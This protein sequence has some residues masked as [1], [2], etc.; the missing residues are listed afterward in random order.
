MSWLILFD[1]LFR[2]PF[3]TGL[4]LAVLLSLTG[5]FLRMR[6]DWLSGLGLSQIAA[7]GGMAALPLHIPVMAGAFGAAGV[8]MLILPILPR[9]TNNHYALM[10]LAGWSLALLIGANSDHGEIIGESL[11]RGQL[12]FTFTPHLWASAIALLI[13]LASVRWLS[14]R[15][16]KQRFFPDF[17]VANRLP[18]W[19]H[20]FIFGSM[21]VA[22]TVLGT[23]SMGALPAFALLF[24]PSWIGF[25]LVDGWTRALAVTIA[26]GV[27]VYMTAF[28][29]A[30][31][32]DQPFGPI[33]TVLLALLTV[34]RWLPAVRRTPD[35]GD[36]GTILTEK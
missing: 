12:Y 16:L 31:L 4:C 3:I 28:V 17:F 26:I 9:A 15:L 25:V 19:R 13:L 7:A 29:M 10:M 35:R 32:A 27:V 30:L 5:A 8:A 34:L 20:R 11:L 6:N 14:P 2:V 36:S 1:P 24:V 22:A 21:V 33:L 23:I 18:A